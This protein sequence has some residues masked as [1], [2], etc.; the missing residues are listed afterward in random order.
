M[1][2]QF[3][4][5]RQCDVVPA[6]LTRLSVQREFK[7]MYDA[8]LACRYRCHRKSVRDAQVTSQRIYVAR[9]SDRFVYRGGLRSIPSWMLGHLQSFKAGKQEI[10]WKPRNAIVLLD[11]GTESVKGAEIVEPGMFSYERI[12]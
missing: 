12:V 6:G 2:A 9:R 10:E 1:H 8:H 4:Q 5:H 7:G 3:R 11:A